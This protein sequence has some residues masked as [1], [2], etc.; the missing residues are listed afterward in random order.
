MEG[1]ILK[2]KTDKLM[3]KGF[4][5]ESMSTYAILTVL[6]QKKDSSWCIRVDRRVINRIKIKYFFSIPHIDDMLDMLEGSK[7]FLKTNL[8]NEYH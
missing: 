7:L 8:R 3:K 2:E 1:E 6:M 4:I 5:R